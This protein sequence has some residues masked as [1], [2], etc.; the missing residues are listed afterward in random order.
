MDENLQKAQHS[1]QRKQPETLQQTQNSQQQQLQQRIQ[2]Q[3]QDKIDYQIVIHLR[4]QA[5]LNTPSQELT[6]PRLFIVLPTDTGF[7][8]R[9]GGPRVADFRLYFLCECG[10]HTRTKNTKIPPE[11]HISKHEGY[12]VD[13]SKEFFDKY[14]PYVLTMMY[15]IKYGAMAA[16]LVVSPLAQLKC[17]EEIDGELGHFSFVKKN[18]SRLVDDM[19]DYLEGTTH[20]T[21][22]N[23]DPASQWNVSLPDLGDLISYLKVDKNESV[24]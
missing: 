1:D 10:T 3:A 15:M 6:I 5:L 16:G 23:E 8:C 21:Y 9:Q 7:I 2:Q 20:A 4:I 24:S 17:I 13:K 12:S 18:I 19:I 22:I 11:V 14:G